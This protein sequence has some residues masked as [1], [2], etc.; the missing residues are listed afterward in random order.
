MINV[1]HFDYLPSPGSRYCMEKVSA[2]LKD[3]LSVKL[4]FLEPTK[5][6]NDYHEDEA[7]LEQ[8]LS[9]VDVLLIH[10]GVKWQKYVLQELPAKFPNLRIGIVAHGIHDYDKKGGIGLI[11]YTDTR[12]IINFIRGD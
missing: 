12:D 6:D 11:D 4:D 9:G 3:D 10:P 2:R 8:R 5:E 1:L 7:V